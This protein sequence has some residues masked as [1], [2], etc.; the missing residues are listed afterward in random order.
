MWY[1]FYGC[2]GEDDTAFEARAQASAVRGSS[3]LGQCVATH[4]DGAAAPVD[5]LVRS[6][7]LVQMEGRH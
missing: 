6:V 3:A 7:A 1:R 4:A 2:E 5:W